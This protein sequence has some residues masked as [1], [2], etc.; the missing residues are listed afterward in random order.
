MDI[1]GILGIDGDVRK[2]IRRHQSDLPHRCRC[3]ARRYRGASSRNR[4]SAPPSTT[5]SPIRPTSPSRSSDS[6]HRG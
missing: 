3:I 6:S 2:R 5:S 1:Q 4:K